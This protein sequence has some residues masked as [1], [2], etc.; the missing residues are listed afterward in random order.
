MMADDLAPFWH[1]WTSSFAPQT[2]S[3]WNTSTLATQH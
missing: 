1:E 3:S 2:I